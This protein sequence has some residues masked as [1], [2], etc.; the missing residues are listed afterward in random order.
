[1]GLDLYGY[2]LGI[3]DCKIELQEAVSDLKKSTSQ[4]S[5]ERTY[6]IKNFLF[7]RIAAVGL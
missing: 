4:F 6:P 2:G 1:M 7:D 3:L 5:L